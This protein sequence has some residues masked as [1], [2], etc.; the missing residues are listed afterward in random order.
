MSFCDRYFLS[1]YSF[2]AFKSIGVAGYL[3]LLFQVFCI[4]LTS[5]NQVFIGRNLGEGKPFLVGP[6]SW[7]MIW[8]SLLTPLLILPLSTLTGNLYFAKLDS[9]TLGKNYFSILMMG[10]FLFPLGA[11][12]AAFLMGLGKTKLLTLVTLAA[13]G[14]NAA[15]DYL[16]INGI[17]GI[18]QPHGIQGAAIATLIAQSF[19]CIILFCI[20]IRS[21]SEKNYQTRSY[22]L[23]LSLFWESLKLS[24]PSAASKFLNLLLWALSI[25]LAARKGGDYLILIS[26][27]STIWIV[28][29]TINESLSKGLLSLFSLFLGQNNWDHIWKSIKSGMYLLSITFLLLGIPLLLFSKQLIHFVIRTELSTTAFH[30]LKLGC[31]WLWIFFILEGVNFMCIS[32][33]LALKQTTYLFIT[34][35][36][37]AFTTVYIPCY[38]A[39]QVG[40]SGPDKI[41]MFTWGCV[42]SST[43][44]YRF[45]ILKCYKEAHAKAKPLTT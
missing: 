5:M 16:L 4:R 45:R 35:T 37:L 13:N 17:P 28:I 9:G 41:W 18:L 33:L 2:E 6:Y 22:A 10:N 19:Y 44:A 36:I 21:P 1:S 3:V 31:Y 15:L 38:L 32:L 40:N 25:H 39:F 27:G 34:S 20:F 24:L 26:F 30:S 14:L 8:C 43:L 23:K 7:Q 29:S 12:L 42:I 11:T